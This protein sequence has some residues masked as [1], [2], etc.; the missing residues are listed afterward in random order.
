MIR[1]L[2]LIALI[3]LIG[4]ATAAYTVKYETILVAEKLR[5]REAEL[6][7]ERDAVAILKAEWQLL[8]RPAR[9][10]ALVPAEKLQ[11]VSIRQIA[12]ATDIPQRGPEED[13]IEDLLTGSIPNTGAA[14]KAQSRTAAAPRGAGRAGDAGGAARATASKVPRPKIVAEKRNAPAAG[15]A[16]VRLTPPGNIGR[17]NTAPAAPPQAAPPQAAAPPSL[18]DRLR[19]A[20]R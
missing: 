19:N 6:Q 4:S 15:A 20:F 5:K 7:R 3:A 14:Q 10:Q 8:N 11:P 1:F 17:P 2:N 12:R 16:P 18:L 9:M 13:R